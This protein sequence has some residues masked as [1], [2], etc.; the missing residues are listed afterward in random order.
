MTSSNS[1][2]ER[3]AIA[4]AQADEVRSRLKRAEDRLAEVDNT[5]RNRRADNTIQ[6]PAVFQF[7]ADHL[8]LPASEVAAY[9]SKLVDVVAGVGDGVAASAVVDLNVHLRISPSLVDADTSSVGV[10]AP[11]IPPVGAHRP[12]HTNTGGA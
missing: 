9:L 12:G 1:S 6:R 7:E 8:R 11:I 5:E 10:C 3:F 4:L 2:A